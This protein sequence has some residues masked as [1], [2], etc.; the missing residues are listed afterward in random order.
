M[1]SKEVTVPGESHSLSHRVNS[2]GRVAALLLA[3]ALPAAFIAGCGKGEPEYY[4]VKEVKE[5]P[6]AVEAE[7]DHVHAQMPAAP[8]E[9]E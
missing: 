3:G 2:A 1:P 5:V 8:G 7:H 6:E 9:L 4:E